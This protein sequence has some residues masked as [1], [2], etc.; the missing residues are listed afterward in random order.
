[1]TLSLFCKTV[2]ST[3]WL[4]PPPPTQKEEKHQ[5]RK[6]LWCVGQHADQVWSSQI[7]PVIGSWIP[8]WVFVDLS[9]ILGPGGCDVRLR[10]WSQTNSIAELWAF[11]PR[12][13][14]PLFDWT[15]ANVVK[16]SSRVQLHALLRAESCLFSAAAFPV[17]H[18]NNAMCSCWK[19]VSR[20]LRRAE[21][22]HQ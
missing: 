5:K 20:Q 17:M 11:G 1:M 9:W 15:G 14:S 13:G 7:R 8:H 4:P 22:W 2:K 10:G 21:R 18:W 12:L 19:K 16:W 3:F 6:Y